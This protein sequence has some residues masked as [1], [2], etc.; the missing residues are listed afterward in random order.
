MKYRFLVIFWRSYTI[1]EK[2]L[3]LEHA[4]KFS[5]SGFLLFWIETRGPNQEFICWIQNLK[6]KDLRLAVE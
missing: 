1:G 2:L 6:T 4:W 3:N 5:I